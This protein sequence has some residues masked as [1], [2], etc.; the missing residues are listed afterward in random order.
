MGPRKE[1][2]RLPPVFA[3]PFEAR[4][5]F[6]IAHLI[7][8]QFLELENGL[9]RPHRPARIVVKGHRL[10]YRN[11]VQSHGLPFDTTFDTSPNHDWLGL[12]M[13]SLH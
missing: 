1:L 5:P 10:D 12:A 2:F 11:A 3:I 4:L 8:R 9:R 6:L 13:G 7:D